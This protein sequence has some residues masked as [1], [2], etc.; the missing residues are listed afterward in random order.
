MALIQSCDQ[1]LSPGATSP[2]D[3]QPPVVSPR[4]KDVDPTHVT[5]DSMSELGSIH[6]SYFGSSPESLVMEEEDEEEM[7]NLLD[8][9]VDSVTE[10]PPLLAATDVEVDEKEM[11]VRDGEGWGGRGESGDEMVRGG[12][13]GVVMKW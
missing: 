9:T 5:G 10:G 13:G 4:R 3:G 12:R 1:L 2:T 7:P 8:T 11:E 6:D